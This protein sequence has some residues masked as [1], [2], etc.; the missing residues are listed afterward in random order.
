MAVPIGDGPGAVGSHLG[1]A[2]VKDADEFP[3][4][5]RAKDSPVSRSDHQGSLRLKH[6]HPAPSGDEI[7]DRQVPV[8]PLIHCKHYQG[9][10]SRRSPGVRLEAIRVLRRDAEFN[11]P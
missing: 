10:C 1:R 6:Q 4:I 11:V 2:C 5:P 8:T 9:R 7:A 3:A